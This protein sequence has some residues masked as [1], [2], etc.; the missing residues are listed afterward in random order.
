MLYWLFV[1]CLLFFFSSRRRHTRCALV[2]G[3][4]TCALP[5][6][7][8]PTGNLGNACAALLAKRM[9]L[10][11]GEIRLATNANDVLPRYLG[12]AD[13][14]PQPIRATLS[15]AMDVG[16]PSNFERLRYWHHDD[17]ALRAALHAQSVDDATIRTVIRRSEEH[18]PELK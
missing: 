16:A 3:V 12:G 4:Q 10:P 18:T 13:Y 5:I 8:V 6:S 1:Y 11:I 9:G 14:A 17:A 2:T 15:N 7:I